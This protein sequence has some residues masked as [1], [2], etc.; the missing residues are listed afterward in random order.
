MSV[1][2]RLQL[3]SRVMLRDVRR[4]LIPLD[5]HAVEGALGGAGGLAVE[6]R[7]RTHA[8]SVRVPP[9]RARGVGQ[10]GAGGR[11]SMSVR[12]AVHEAHA[13]VGGEARDRRPLRTVCRIVRVVA[14][15]GRRSHGRPV[16]ALELHVV[17]G[18]E[19]LVYGERRR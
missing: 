11:V 16:D 17:L 4:R 8:P 14:F 6:L 7:G 9:S 13:L 19:P 3:D 5:A 1:E 2:P 15:A 10:E 18:E 12:V